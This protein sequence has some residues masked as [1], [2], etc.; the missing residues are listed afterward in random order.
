MSILVTLK[1]ILII[2]LILVVVIGLGTRRIKRKFRKWQ[3]RRESRRIQKA[4]VDVA[5]E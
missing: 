2:A 3:E 1:D 4:M 5:K